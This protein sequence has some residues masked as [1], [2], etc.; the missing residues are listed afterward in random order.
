VI[1]PDIV[2]AAVQG[3][4]EG[5]TEFLPVS[6]TGHL[7]LSG[8]LLGFEDD[9][10][11]T[12]DIFIQLG[13]ILA[14]VWIYR[15]RFLEV[16][17]T[18]GREPASRRFISNLALGFLPAAVLG[19][20]LHHWIKAHLFSPITVAWA[21]L[22]GGVL[23]LLIERWHPTERVS[24]ARDLPPLTA[25]G[26][27]LAQTIALFPGMSRS[28][29]TILGGYSLGLSRTAATEFSFFLA[30]PTLAAAAGYDLLKSLPSLAPAD[31][32][33]F[34]I[35]FLVAFGSAFVVVK[36]FLRYVAHHSFSAFAWYRIALGGL[37]LWLA[38]RGTLPGG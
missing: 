9:R 24:D 15:Q 34:G 11:K 33:L 26:I 25:F 27:G 8:H 35:G 29:A 12:F 4:V 38:S 16:A 36:A 10:A 23:I 13:A 28:A 20:L 2:A 22:V 18:V 1:L 17:R 37:L 7:I 30:V 32:P 31:A 21:L 6:S 14:I 3:V 5:I 19:L